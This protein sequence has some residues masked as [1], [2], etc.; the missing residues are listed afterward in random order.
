MKYF[1]KMIQWYHEYLFVNSKDWQ[2]RSK[3]LE[4]DFERKLHEIAVIDSHFMV[5]QTLATLRVSQKIQDILAEDENTDVL[6]TLCWNNVLTK[7]TYDKLL[8]KNIDSLILGLEKRK[9]VDF[10]KYGRF[11]SFK[12]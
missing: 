8:L 1:I 12:D 11:T 9:K 6:I 5:R 4:A 7:K 3:L 2:T 10:I